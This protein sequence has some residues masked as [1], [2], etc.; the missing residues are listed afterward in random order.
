MTIQYEAE[1]RQVYFRC[2]SRK[3]PTVYVDC[4]GFEGNPEKCAAIIEM[5]SPTNLK[6]EQRLVGPMTSLS[7]FIP[8]LA[9]RIR[10]MLKKM[11]K[12]SGK[13]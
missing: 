12:G 5:E 7:R 1:P 3:I 10:S 4:L 8:K 9:E 11:K 2:G 13:K 6:E